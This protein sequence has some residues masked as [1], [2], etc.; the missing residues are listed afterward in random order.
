MQHGIVIK[1]VSNVGSGL[2]REAGGNWGGGE[3]LWNEIA[4]LGL[5]KCHKFQ[6]EGSLWGG[7]SLQLLEGLNWSC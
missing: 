1:G 5:S 2:T 7:G 3:G 6:A 4:Q